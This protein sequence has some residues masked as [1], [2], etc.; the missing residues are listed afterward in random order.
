MGRCCHQQIVVGHLRQRLAK[1]V[2][3]RFL[4]SAYRAHLVSF[5]HDEEVPMAS[6]QTFLRVLDAR[7][8]RNGRDDLILILPRIRT[9]IGSEYIAADDLEIL[10]ELILHLTLPLKRKTG[11]R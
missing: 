5:I 1:L 6:Q 3:K 8:P 9:V 7:D 2:G 11:W 4:I 10:A